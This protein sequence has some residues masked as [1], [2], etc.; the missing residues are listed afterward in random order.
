MSL[1]IFG[2]SLNPEPQFPNLSNV[3]LNQRIWKLWP[4]ETVASR[5]VLSRAYCN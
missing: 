4:Q 1:V 5:D 3:A 2:K